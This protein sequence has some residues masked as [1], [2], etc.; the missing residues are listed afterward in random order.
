MQ[1][2]PVFAAPITDKEGDDKASLDC[3]ATKKNAFME[4]AG[5]GG[6]EVGSSPPYL[7]FHNVSGNNFLRDE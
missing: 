7:D 6:R 2:V 5:E 4:I 1:K 3:D